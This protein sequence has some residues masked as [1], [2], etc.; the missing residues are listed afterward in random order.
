MKLDSKLPEV[1]I[2]IFSVMTKLAIDS[3]FFRKVIVVIQFTLAVV[4]ITGSV[5]IMKQLGFMG[6]KDLGYEKENI[7][8]LN[9]LR[10]YYAESYNLTNRIKSLKQE[11]MD[12]PEITAVSASTD[13][14]CSIGWSNIPVWE[15]K[16]ED[17]NPFFYRMIVDYDFFDL[18]GI[19]LRDGRYFSRDMATDDG[20]AYI[21]N[22]AA[23]D[24][25]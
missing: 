13:V 10:L 18:Y 4:L 1:G 7:V 14:P 20:N 24:R 21:I 2:T 5:T 8:C 22:R 15:G 16:E 23:A 12:N 19:K 17:D 6:K 11:L 9:L 25:M 3:Q